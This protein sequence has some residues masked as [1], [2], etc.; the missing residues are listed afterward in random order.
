LT[1]PD[2]LVRDQF[3]EHVYDVFLRRELKS[4]IRQRPS[5][6]FLAL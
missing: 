5:I 6:S 1:D 4:I 3:V 2:I